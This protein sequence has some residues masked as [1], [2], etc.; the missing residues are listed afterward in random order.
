MTQSAR[1]IHEYDSK[2]YV[3]TISCAPPAIYGGCCSHR[4]A[5]LYICNINIGHLIS[6]N[7]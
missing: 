6:P 5:V 4:Q 7:S 1:A 2:L 3:T